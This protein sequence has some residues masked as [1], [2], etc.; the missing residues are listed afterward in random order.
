VLELM[1][2]EGTALRFTEETEQG[3]N[4]TIKLPKLTEARPMRPP[5]ESVPG[6]EGVKRR[7]RAP[8]VVVEGTGS[9]D[10]AVK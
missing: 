9:G 3:D 4:D 1:I 2:D 8:K 7:R 6:N 5:L 10:A